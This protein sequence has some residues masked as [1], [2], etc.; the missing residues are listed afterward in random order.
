MNRALVF[1]LC[2]LFA[3]PDGFAR[4][5]LTSL[6]SKLDALLTLA[7]STGHDH[8]ITLELER[9][10]EAF[11]QCQRQKHESF[12][13]QGES[14]EFFVPVDHVLLITDVEYNAAPADEVA[15]G[16]TMSYALRALRPNE[17]LSPQLEDRLGP[18]PVAI[19][20]TTRVSGAR[21]LTTPIVMTAGTAPCA[22]TG[23]STTAALGTRSILRGVLL[24][25]SNES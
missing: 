10:F 15:A 16:R 12:V 3:A 5:S 8:I 19:P 9:N 4:T 22:A 23:F 6:D 18:F 14:D 2:L 13:R 25:V 24:P 20:N 7:A 1:T 17:R 21:S 11:S